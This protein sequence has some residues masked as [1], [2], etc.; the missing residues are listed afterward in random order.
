[1]GIALSHEVTPHRPGKSGPRSSG[2]K[3]GMRGGFKRKGR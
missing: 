3:A 1:M 2:G